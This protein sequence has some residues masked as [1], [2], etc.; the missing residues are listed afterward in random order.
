MTEA[1]MADAI[2]VTEFAVPAY[3][4]SVRHLGTVIAF[5][6]AGLAAASFGCSTG[7]TGTDSDWSRSYAYSHERVW[8]A[9]TNTLAEGNYEVESS[10]PERGRIRVVTGS[11]HNYRGLLLDVQLTQRGEFV[12][13]SVQ[14]RGGSAGTQ[15]EYKRVEQ[16]V[17]EFLHDLDNT[18]RG[19][20]TE[21]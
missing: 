19:P 17:V 13:V 2:E 15:V 3:C 5:V 18:L 11:D 10:D 8:K 1:F 21:G 14:G 9:V 4:R 6:S 20:P 12:I 16:A 7:A